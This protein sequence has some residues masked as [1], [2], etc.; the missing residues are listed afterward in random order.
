VPRRLS[1]AGR[2]RATT[3]LTAAAACRLGLDCCL[4]LA[5]EPPLVPSGNLA[6]EALLGAQIIWAGDVDDDKLGR[7][8]DA[9]SSELTSSGKHVEVIP[10]GGSDV[11]GAHGYIDC[12]NELT[13]QIPGLRHVVVAAGSGGTM[14]G[15]VAAL[16]PERVLGIDTGAVPDVADR[17]SGMLDGLAAEG[18]M[19]PEHASQPLRL[20]RDQIG[21]GYG[22]LTPQ[23]RDALIDAAHCEGIILD[24][25]YTAK[26]LSG[27]A[28]AV[29]DGSINHDDC[30][31]FLLTGGLPGLFGHDFIRDPQRHPPRTG[32]A[33]I[34]LLIEAVPFTARAAGAWAVLPDRHSRDSRP[35]CPRPAPACE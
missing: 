11:R 23:A 31:V 13:A 4:V 15:L 16:G 26:A 10:F 27:L 18:A 14:A 19:P 9:V 35:R 28:A 17:I 2:P 8:V 29:A 1:P 24:P 21:P 7:R 25:V 20:R 30:T 32:P 22:V 12:G 33:A 3:R 5:G 34:M 6:L